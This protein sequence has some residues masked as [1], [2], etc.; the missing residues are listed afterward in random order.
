MG[1]GLIALPTHVYL[2][3]AELTAAQAQLVPGKLFV[4]VVHLGAVPLNKL[5][6]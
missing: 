5:R 4:E 2:E 1:A 6:S 3:D